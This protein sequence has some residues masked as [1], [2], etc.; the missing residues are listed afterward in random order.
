MQLTH[1][2]ELLAHKDAGVTGESSTEFTV[3]CGQTPYCRVG[4]Q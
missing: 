2:P 1:L 3:A 4:R